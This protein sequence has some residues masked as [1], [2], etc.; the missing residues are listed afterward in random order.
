MTLNQVD[1]SHNIATRKIVF[2]SE[3]IVQIAPVDQKS[4]LWDGVPLS[5]VSLLWKYLIVFPQGY[6]EVYI[7]F[8]HLA[9]HC[10]ISPP[11]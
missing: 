8:S 5:D 9:E 1:I 4:K 2:G 11:P 10:S 3:F 7:D 6:T